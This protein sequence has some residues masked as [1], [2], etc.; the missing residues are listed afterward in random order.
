MM[1]TNKKDMHGKDI[2]CGDKV[3][4]DDQEFIIKYGNYTYLGTDRIGF[5]ME[6]ILTPKM[7]LPLNSKV[8]KI[9]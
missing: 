7:Q 1:K 5:F 8:E 3:L 2:F 9:K 4:F 6:Q